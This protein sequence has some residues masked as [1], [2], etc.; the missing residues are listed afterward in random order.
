MLPSCFFAR[1]SGQLCNMI[2]IHPNHVNHSF[3]FCAI[4]GYTMFTKMLAVISK[5]GY[6]YMVNLWHYAFF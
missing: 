5:N 1:A 6:N 3:Y 4:T 2:F